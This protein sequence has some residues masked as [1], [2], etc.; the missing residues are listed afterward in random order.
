MLRSLSRSA[1]FVAC[2]LVPPAVSA[3]GVPALEALIAR[4][5]PCAELP[6]IDRLDFVRVDRMTLVAEGEELAAT[7]SGA[8]GCESPDDAL[9][10]ASVSAAIDASVAV[11]LPDCEI[12]EAGATLSDIGGT[13]GP[14]LSALRLEAEAALADE[15]AGLARDTCVGL[16]T[17]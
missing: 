16:F 9:I 12:L 6:G 7:L 3:Q 13:A 1:A 10:P 4:D 5:N 8:L 11:R 15:I 17:E 2:L 14:L